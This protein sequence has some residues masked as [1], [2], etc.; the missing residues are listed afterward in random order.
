[1]NIKQIMLLRY[2]NFMLAFC[3]R[4]YGLLF[5][6]RGMSLLTNDTTNKSF[7]MIEV[8]SLDIENSI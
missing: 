7:N 4:P 1:M 5:I 8:T 2:T 6:E 3:R